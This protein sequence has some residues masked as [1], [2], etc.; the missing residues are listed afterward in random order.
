MKI[1][2]L[3]P[4]YG[5]EE[6]AIRSFKAFTDSELKELDA[7]LD[8]SIQKKRF[9]VSVSGEDEE[10]CAN[11][12]YEAFGK[13]LTPKDIDPEAEC[14]GFIQSVHADHLVVN[15]GFD[16]IVPLSALEPLGV[17]SVGQIASRFGMI[18]YLPVSFQILPDGTAVFTKKQVDLWW[19]WKKS[20][21][22]RIFVNGVTR[23]QVKAVL[24]R[25]RHGRDVYGVE[26]LGLTECVI[27][28]KEKTDG[29]GIV[30][31]IGRKLQSSQM[32]VLIGEKKN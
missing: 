24:Q 11:F 19:S 31:S 14:S 9:V 8:I 13:L 15:A 16:C 2:L 20:S 22:D 27:I 32:G 29:P 26:K 18:P 4:V 17:G 5:S 10:L 21:T 1:D 28:C 23:S 12:L 3:Q 25:S 30:A 6:N 7:S